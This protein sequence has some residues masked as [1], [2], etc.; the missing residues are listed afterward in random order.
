MASRPLMFAGVG[1][2]LVGLAF[3]VARP[4]VPDPA[5]NPYAGVRG[6][7]RAK[8]AGLLVLLR[9]RR[10]SRAHRRARD[11]AARGRPAALRR[12]RRATA[13]R[14]GAAARRRAAAGDAV[15]GRGG[16]DGAGRSRARRC[17]SRS[18]VVD[19]RRPVVV[20][21]MFSD[22]RAA[23]RRPGRRRDRS[24]HDRDR[25]GVGV[26]QIAPAAPPVAGAPAAP[27]VPPAL[28]PF[29][30]APPEAPP[31]APP[32]PPPPPPLPASPV[33]D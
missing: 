23:G 15:P 12:A 9:A 32:G 22:Q 18:T 2:L 30:L 7:S 14:R 8:A 11:R 27:A 4:R 17:P 13:S 24:D 20:T 21:A 5:T 31:L 6:A 1:V 29:P 16:R 28:P 10:R 33:T 25:Q 19:G 3:L 26:A